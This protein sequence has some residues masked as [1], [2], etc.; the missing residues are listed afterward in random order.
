MHFSLLSKV[1]HCLLFAGCQIKWEL[2]AGKGFLP[3]KRNQE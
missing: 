2:D 3:E 1:D